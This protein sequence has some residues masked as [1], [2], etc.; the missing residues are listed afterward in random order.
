MLTTVTL[1]VYNNTFN[2][3]NQSIVG[4]MGVDV[5]DEELRKMEP[6][7]QL[8]PGGYSFCTDHD[9]Y[10]VFHPGLPTQVDYLDDPP[11]YDL[12]DV[13]INN[14]DIIEVRNNMID[15]RSG[16]ATLDVYIK[17]LDKKCIIPQRLRYYYTP[18][19]QTTFS[20]AIVLPENRNF[21][22]EA[23]GMN[24]TKGGQD[25][26]EAEKEGVLIS[27]WPFCWDEIIEGNQTVAQQNLSATLKSQPSKCNLTLVQRLVFDFEATK[28]FFNYSK[29]SS[30]DRE[31]VFASFVMTEGGLSRVFPPEKSYLLDGLM[32]PYTSFLYKRA[33]YSTSS[34]F[35]VPESKVRV[36][37]VSNDTVITVVRAFTVTD[38]KGKYTPGV[39]GMNISATLLLETFFLSE[40]IDSIC[41]N[42][43]DIALCYLL[44][45][46]AFIV[47]TNQN[48]NLDLIG[49]FFGSH[50]PHLMTELHMKGVYQSIDEFNYEAR[51]PKDQKVNRGFRHMPL[52]SSFGS[53]LS[54][55]WIFDLSAWYQA[56]IWLYSL[57]SSLW[58]QHGE[59]FPE[60]F[61]EEDNTT[62]CITR[63]TKY[64]LGSNSTRASEEIE[65]NNCSRVFSVAKVGMTNLL[66]VITTP[67]CIDVQFHPLLPDPPVP[68]EVFPDLCHPHVKYRVRPEKCFAFHKLED[69]T[70]CSAIQLHSFLQPQFFGVGVLIVF[71]PISNLFHPN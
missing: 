67:P 36:F 6:S 13:E 56:R 59:S 14:K 2:G 47:A 19:D 29:Y 20:V 64:Y 46:A 23:K 69:S 37:D 53:L 39:V 32:D 21:H 61:Y 28:Y 35:I 63:L 55:I 16:N 5:T 70:K 54:V 26:N 48:N 18:V 68:V 30:G 43:T 31:H 45:D 12:T 51:C 34:V 58:W 9:G 66:L 57:I 41:Y 17:M 62:H 27:P 10:I 8:G 38:G 49:L 22:L 71:I 50:D 1:P 42:K 60:F 4:V 52:G 7:A 3:K 44:D 24:L 25:L 11:H 40:E 33:I 15:R 65:F